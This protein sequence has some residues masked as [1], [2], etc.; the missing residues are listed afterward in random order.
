[1]IAADDARLAL[2]V[3]ASEA[4][5]ISDWFCSGAGASMKESEPH[6]HIGIDACSCSAECLATFVRGMHDLLVR[7]R[8]LSWAPRE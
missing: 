2:R 5:I 6:T 8:G 3:E 4:L 7:G 1:M